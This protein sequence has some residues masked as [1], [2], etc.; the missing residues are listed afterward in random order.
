MFMDVR[1]IY[2]NN[3]LMQ[4]DRPN[5]MVAHSRIRATPKENGP[6]LAQGNST[7]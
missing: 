5:L 2:I 4:I 3:K 7:I 1:D 6:A